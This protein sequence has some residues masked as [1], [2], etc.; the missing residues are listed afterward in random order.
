MPPSPGKKRR[1]TV[2]GAGGKLIRAL[3]KLSPTA[4]IIGLLACILVPLPTV[5]VDLA[6]SG[7]LALAVLLLVAS[8]RVRR[9]SEFLSFPTLLLFVTLFRLALNVSTTRLILGHADAGR[10]VDAFAEF[11]V[12][13]DV[14]IG[15]VMFSIVTAVQYLVIARGSERVAEVGARFALDG[16]PGHQAAIDADLRAGVISAGE[17]SRRRSSLAERSNFYGAMDGAIRFVKGDAIAGLVITGI[18]LIGGLAIGMGRQG[19]EWQSSLELYGKLTIGDGLIA[20]IPALLV[21]LAAGILVSRVD[22]EDGASGGGWLEPAMLLVPAL[23]LAILAAIPGMPHVAFATVAVA[24]VAVAIVLA[25]WR[26]GPEADLT[27][28]QRISI[29]VDSDLVPDPR[30]HR[31]TLEM[32]RQR[33]EDALGVEVPPLELASAAGARREMEIRLGSRMLGR[34]TLGEDVEHGLLLGGFRAIMASAE[35]FVDLQDVDA[36]I[37][38]TRAK[39][40]AVVRRALERARPEDVLH[41][42]RGFLRERIPVPPMDALLGSLADGAI[43]GDGEEPDTWPERARRHLSDYWVNDLL[44]GLERL[45]RPRCVRPTPDLELELL[46]HQRLESGRARL[47]LSVAERESWIRRLLVVDGGSER[48]GEVRPTYLVVSSRARLAFA[49]LLARHTPHVPVLA[50]EELPEAPRGMAVE[51]CWVDLPGP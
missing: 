40:P 26:P 25:V 31:R 30:R 13:G 17:A 24:L 4:L 27:P 3:P 19:L 15:A 16:L 18:N 9:S 6:L 10:V 41:I 23:L 34:A 51:A 35:S 7:S 21:S 20:Q 32:L 14:V 45:G 36:W 46:D 39:K 37:E 5:L 12:R 22:R 43:V 47:Q 1:E 11:V 38:R 50:A 8:L 2:K 29:R 42:V 44:D 48:E 28:P 49:E 33:C